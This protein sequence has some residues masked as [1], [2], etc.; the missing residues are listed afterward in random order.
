MI[1]GPRDANPYGKL[2][3]PSAERGKSNPYGKLNADD[4]LR[5]AT[6]AGARLRGKLSAMTPA[7]RAD[8]FMLIDAARA[9]LQVTPARLCAEASV[10]RQHYS[11]L[12]VAKGRGVSARLLLTLLRALKTTRAGLA[13]G[14]EDTVEPR[15]IRAAYHGCVSAVIV[16][17]AVA[18]T[19]DGALTILRRRSY[20]PGDANWL[21]ACQIRRLALYLASTELGLRGGQLALIAGLTPAAVSIALGKIEDA[22]DDPHFEAAMEKAAQTV[23]GREP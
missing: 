15:V 17:F 19:A 16:P 14:V 12:H 22:M 8:F 5:L 13:R 3:A 9:N 10:S 11:N 21:Q 1:A 7:A 6:Q 18:M 23:R 20:S 2:N 4:P